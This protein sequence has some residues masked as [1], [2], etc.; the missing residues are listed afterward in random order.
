MQ[1]LKLGTAN[2]IQWAIE[3]YYL[4]EIQVYEIM[5]KKEWF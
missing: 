4:C 5:Y 2:D 3:Q 1:Q